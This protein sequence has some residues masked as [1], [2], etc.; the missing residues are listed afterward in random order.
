LGQ[1]KTNVPAARGG[2]GAA[3]LVTVDG[4]ILD[5]NGFNPGIG[6]LTDG[7]SIN[8]AVTNDGPGASTLTVGT[9]GA[10]TT[11]GGVLRDGASTLALLKAGAGTLTLAGVN[12]YSGPTNV[13]SGALNVIGSISGSAVT[14]DGGTLGGTG[15]VGATT[16]NL[17]GTFAPGVGLG[18]LSVAGSLSLLGTANFEINKT[19]ALL[20]ADL[21]NVSGLVTFG[22]LLNVLATGDA[23]D[24]GDRFDLFDAPTFAGSFGSLNLPT[25]TGDL[26]WDTSSLTVDGSIAVV[27][28]PG[29]FASLLG[30]LAVLLGLR[31][32]RRS[33]V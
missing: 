26:T 8:G 15:S 14:V 24:A 33:A 20:S 18:S 29:A 32:G 13:T 2:A 7:G 28:E 3:N 11:F 17:G 31:R 21:A 4:G 30:G 19:G 25:L 16:V 12:T 10:S 6:G 22:G 1:S 9:S 27:P 5:L 23:L